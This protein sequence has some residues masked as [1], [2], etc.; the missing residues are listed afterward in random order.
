MRI[1]RIQL[2]GLVA[3][4]AGAG[5]AAQEAAA[6]DL[7][8]TTATTTPVVTSNPAGGDPGNVTINSG[9]SIAVTA[10][11]TAVTVDSNNNVTNSGTIASSN[12]NNSTGIRLTN[13]FAGTIINGSNITL[14][15]TF[16]PTDGDNDGDL[17]GPFAQGTNRNGIL[18]D[19][20]TFIGNVTS[21]GTITIEGNNSAGI[22]LNG[23]L[24]GDL[25]LNG[26]FDITGDDSHGV[27]IDGGAAGGVTGDVFVLGTN[28]VRGENSTGL[29]VNGA[30]G[31][32][33]S[34]SGAWVVSGYRFTTRPV[35]VSD[36]DADD[37][38]QGGSAVDINFSVAGGVT[39]EGIGVEDDD[40]DDD[41]GDVEGTPD[42]DA[43]DDVGAT[44]RGIGGAPTVHVQADASANL[45]LGPTTGPGGG[46]GLY[47]RGTI[48]S[49]GVYD[50]IVATT[51]RVEGNGI[52][53]TDLSAGIRNDRTISSSA[54]EADAYSIY[55]GANAIVPTVEN[56]LGI[57]AVSISETNQEARAIYFASGAQAGAVVN[58][59]TIRAQIF[60]ETGGAFGIVD[61]SNT[62]A[63]ITNSGAIITEA[64]ATDSDLTDDVTPVANGDTIAIDV[65]ASTIAV[66]LN[67]IADTPFTDDDGEDDD[68][69][70]RPDTTI[71]GDILFGTGADTINLGA[72][73]I[74]G[75]VS[76][77][78]GADVF[79][80]T[81]GA[82]FAGQIT[83]SDNALTLNVTNGELN[84]QGGT[85]NITSATFGADALFNPLLTTG[86]DTTHVISSGA[87]TFLAGAEVRPAVPTGLPDSGTV[88]F[89]T[90][91]GG[92]F[93]GAN[94]VNPDVEGEGVPFLY[95]L[96]VEL[97]NPLAPD[98]A[99][100]GLQAEFQMKTAAELGFNANQAAAFDPIIDALRLDDDA[101]AAF[102]ALDNQFD[103]FD[104]YEDLLPSFASGATELAA[105]AIQQMQGASSNRLAA[106]RLQDLDE[107]SIW[108]QEIAYGLTREPPS[109]Q[110][111]E[112]RGHGFG[113]AGGIDGPLDNGGLFGLSASFITSEVEEPGRPEG[114]IS[115]TF[116]QL[117]AYWGA[118]LGPVDLDFVGGAGAGKM[119]SRR[120][121]EIGDTFT[122]LSEAD[123]W[124]YEGHGSA[125]ASVPMRMADW[126][127]ILPQAQ[128]TYVALS[129]QGYT[130]SGGGDA[131]D[132]EVDDAFSQRLWGDVGLE[133][134][135][136]LNLRGGAVVAP[137]IYAGY[138]ANLI[139]EEAE[140]SFRFV[141]GTE[142]FTLSDE[143]LGDGGPLVGIG[144]DATNGYSTFS[145]G[146]E[147]EFGDQVE[148][149]SLNA[150]IRFRF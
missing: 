122:A 136:R 92:L 127:V 13:G 25:I 125:R 18:L 65:S 97:T 35:D 76:F 109:L 61:E 131:I 23:E 94:V 129:E 132:Y 88:V 107:V 69:N 21:S 83:D 72:G 111:Q 11:Q 52:R 47:N 117:N 26:G 119:Q 15:E 106:T 56:R 14:N 149:H 51:I 70:N 19:P 12:A 104:A 98:G 87:V 22:R 75:D 145:L 142:E 4:L 36:L 85:L 130:E 148:R 5:G 90:A 27:I 140:R 37:L 39:F 6:D 7:T 71:V 60:G 44:V 100:N 133:F 41:D 24:D 49:E 113:L 115:T 46:F 66:T 29:T 123:W 57:G 144:L 67:Q 120:F 81:N 77:N 2:A 59:G 124:A 91:N 79:N 143:G 38:L 102:T 112:F 43:N 3:A 147:G 108:A 128:L 121:V 32:A 31:G 103:F 84:L 68:E 118:A 40:D 137:R 105:T 126:L 116:G 53:T 54:R 82:R 20:G 96:A 135:A 95:N 64:I 89:L 62:V 34:I 9:G 33:L 63:T 114:E 58:S 17:D 30:I 150:A 1:S 93:G 101:S 99:V 141:S 86:V 138:R 16:A 28:I 10:G 55:V 78:D 50:G 74:I 42:N 73:D 8:I 48:I 45:L 80:I 146:Y 134:T 110:G 139:D